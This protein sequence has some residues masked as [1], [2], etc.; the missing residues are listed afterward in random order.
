[1]ADSIEEL[2]A[3]LA[4]YE[5]NGAGK[6]FYALNRKLNE[7][8]EL[9]NKVDLSKVDLDDKDSKQ[10]DRLFKILEKSK[11]VGDAAQTIQGFAGITGDE[12]KDTKSP[13]YR[14]TPESMAQELGDN[15]TQDV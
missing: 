2:K 1:M 9:L 4:L 11:V 15:K 7:M 8:A 5:Q 10:F 3:R 14:I 12:Q 13:K 6:F